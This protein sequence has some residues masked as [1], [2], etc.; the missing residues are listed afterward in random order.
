MQYW[1]TSDTHFSHANILKYCSR[2]LFMT[3][4][5]REIFDNL[6]IDKANR[7]RPSQESLNNMNLGLIRRWNERVKKD[8]AVIFLGD[9]CFKNSQNRGEGE[10]IKAISWEEQ[11][12][13]KIIFIKGNHDRNNSVKTRIHS[14]QLRIDGHYLNC[15]HDP[16]YAN[17]C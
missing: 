6:A 16:V 14:L 3:K 7:W 4:E 15:V 11:L 17:K 12:N 13:G 2:T 8:D 5:D 10:N 1:F 9:F